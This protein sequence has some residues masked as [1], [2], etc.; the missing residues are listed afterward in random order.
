MWHKQSFTQFWSQSDAYSRRSS[1]KLTYIHHPLVV[2]THQICCAVAVPIAL[3]QDRLLHG[4]NRLVNWTPCSRMRESKLKRD[5]NQLKTYSHHMISYLTNDQYLNE[6]VHFWTVCHPLRIFIHQRH[7]LP[8]WLAI[9]LLAFSQ[10]GRRSTLSI[11]SGYNYASCFWLSMSSEVIISQN[12]CQVLRVNFF[13]GPIHGIVL[14]FINTFKLW[15]IDRI[16]HSDIFGWYRAGQCS[17]LNRT[18]VT[19]DQILIISLTAFIMP[20]I[21][22]IHVSPYNPFIEVQPEIDST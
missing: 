16:G 6:P 13:L 20:L 7:G 19:K 4:H 2:C 17:T 12:V 22:L 15:V 9:A 3:S 18:I 5:W 10:S 14:T 8:Y 1:L 21:F 11:Q